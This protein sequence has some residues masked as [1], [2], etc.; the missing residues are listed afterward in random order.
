MRNKWK[1]ESMKECERE[2]INGMNAYI[3]EA[4]FVV[5]VYDDAVQM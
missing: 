5:V 4:E 1:Y 3:N 2:W